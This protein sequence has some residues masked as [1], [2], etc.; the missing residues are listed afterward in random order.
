[1]TF[2]KGRELCSTWL[3]RDAPVPRSISTQDSFSTALFW[4]LTSSSPLLDK[5]FMVALW[6]MAAQCR[7]V[8]PEVRRKT[9]VTWH[10]KL[11][12]NYTVCLASLSVNHLH[13][14]LT[15]GKITFKISGLQVDSWPA[16][17]N[18]LCN[19]E[20][21]LRFALYSSC[22]LVW[23]A[24]VTLKQFSSS[25]PAEPQVSH[26]GQPG[27][28][29]FVLWHHRHWCPLL[30]TAGL[31]QSLAGLPS[32]PPVKQSARAQTLVFWEFM[33]HA[34]VCYLKKKKKI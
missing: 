14:V 6:E 11:G 22:D 1:M 10:W 34:C 26:S 20:S 23:W 3:S 25:L 28:G 18:C 15:T 33:I 24:I 7:G 2:R 21:L 13:I 9:R 8:I 4:R 17:Q 29:Q 19:K 31:A 12:L 27:E 5:A 16:R 30:M 32:L